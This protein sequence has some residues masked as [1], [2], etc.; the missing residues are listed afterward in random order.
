MRFFFVFG[1]NSY[2]LSTVRI[3]FFF[4]VSFNQRSPSFCRRRVCCPITVVVRPDKAMEK[5][6][7]HFIINF[8]V[9]VTSF[10]GPGETLRRLRTL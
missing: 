2:G 3:V 6:R 7:F 1:F 8:A 9:S 5:I 4:F 10:Y